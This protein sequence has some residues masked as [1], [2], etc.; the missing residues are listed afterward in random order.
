MVI[1]MQELSLQNLEKEYSDAFARHLK[2][3]L[4]ESGL[5]MRELARRTG[6]DHTALS[7]IINGFTGPSLGTVA[8]IAK[9]FNV[10]IDSLIDFT[11]DDTSDDSLDF[12]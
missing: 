7:R 10:S 3:L 11:Y 5:S 4:S 2:S 12:L 9:Y 8:A 6:V 1:K